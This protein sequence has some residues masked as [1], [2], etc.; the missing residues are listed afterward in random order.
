MNI[1]STKGSGCA[2]K[3][4]LTSGSFFGGMIENVK[5]KNQNVK[6]KILRLLHIILLF[7]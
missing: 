2:K 3:D 6:L 7:T 4:T 5:L 1:I